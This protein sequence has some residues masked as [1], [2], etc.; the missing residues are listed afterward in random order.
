MVRCEQCNKKLG[1]NDYKCRCGKILCIKHLQAQ[2]HDCKF[3][4]KTEAQ[5]KLKKEMYIG[6]LRTKVESI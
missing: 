4:Y 5:I 3:D 6:P 1:I 2:F